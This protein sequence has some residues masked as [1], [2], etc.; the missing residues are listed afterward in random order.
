VQFGQALDLLRGLHS[1]RDLVVLG[2][3]GGKGLAVAGETLPQL[4]GSLRSIWAAAP[5][6]SAQALGLAVAQ[7]KE[8]RLEEPVSG[9]LR[10]DLEVRRREPVAPGAPPGA[11]Q[12]AATSALAGET[13]EAGP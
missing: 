7:Q 9:L 11:A 12:P 10:V 5:S 8:R 13:G 3:F 6:G 4:P 2:V 1:R